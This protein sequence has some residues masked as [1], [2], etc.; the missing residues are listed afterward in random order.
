MHENINEPLTPAAEIVG[1]GFSRGRE[2]ELQDAIGFAPTQKRTL[3][4]PHQE[5]HRKAW[6]EDTQQRIARTAS[7]VR[8]IERPELTVEQFQTEIG[9]L[10]VQTER[11]VETYN[12]SEGK[13]NLPLIEARDR[14]ARPTAELA[15]AKAVLVDE[16]AKGS[17]LD[18]F[19]TAITHVENRVRGLVGNFG[20]HVRKQLIIDRLGH[21]PPAERISAGLKAEVRQHVRIAELDRYL[22]KPLG[23]AFADRIDRSDADLLFKRANDV[24][25]K[26]D[27]FKQHIE[28]EAR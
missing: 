23:E 13:P 5:Q 7:R 4:N 19:R 21:V 18:R 1:R 20:E 16:E 15:E 12:E 17:I 28:Q 22:P 9:S 11:A 2:V 27:A 25:N 3:Q 26:L 10:S 14:V 8:R 24:A 6:E